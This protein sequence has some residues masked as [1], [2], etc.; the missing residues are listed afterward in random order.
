MGRPTDTLD[1]REVQRRSSAAGP[2]TPGV[3]LVYSNGE[4]LLG[5]IALGGGAIELGRGTIGGV[6]IEDPHMSRRH[7]QVSREGANWVVRDLGSRNGMV[8]DGVTLRE[9]VGEELRLLRLGDSLFLFA[10]DLRPLAGGVGVADEQV[11]GPAMH[12]VWDQIGAAARDGETLHITGESGAGKELAARAFHALGPRADGPFVAVNCAAIPEGVA[13][14]L[15]FGARRGAFSGAHESSDGYL[16]A[17]HGGTLFLDEV[18]DLDAAIQ[19]KLLRVLETR[20]VMAIG[21]TKPRP[22]DLRIC[23]ATHRS[24]RGLVG[25]KKF[26]EDLYFRIGRPHIELPPLRERP[27]EVPYLIELELRRLGGGLRADASFV[28]AC[29]LRPWPGNVRE[30]RA[31]VREAAR[32]AGAD[33]DVVVDASRLHEAAGTRF[34]DGTAAAPAA[35]ASVPSTIELPAAL[36]PRAEIEDA[37]R[38]AGGKVATAARLLGLH[39]NQLRRWLTRHGLD[40][41]AFGAKEE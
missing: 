13:E 27:E 39:R 5:P 17:A 10:D 23:S 14:R 38:K 26:R 2:P 32:R 34:A 41:A 12:R 30:L 35:Q 37:L 11:R 19:G 24:L 8:V 33:G 25:E 29:L 22:V 15:L 21:D 20:E 36:P 31:E 40:A 6:R 9:A 18:G 4:A 7:A 1:L 28:E 16:Q 3:A